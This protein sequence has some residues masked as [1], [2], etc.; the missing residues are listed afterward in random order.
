MKWLKFLGL[1]LGTILLVAPIGVYIFYFWNC[2]ISDN[3]TDWGVFGDFIGGVYSIIVTILAV[4]LASAL[5]KRDH[6][7]EKQFKAAEILYNQITTIENNNCNRRSIEKLKRDIHSNELYLDPD[8]TND[9]I[10]LADQFLEQKD[11]TGNVD[12]E[13]KEYVMSQLKDLYEQ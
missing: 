1:L 7:K 2:P 13:F 8:I 5:T 10:K 6:K 9:V 11:G 12:I 4:Y 3:P